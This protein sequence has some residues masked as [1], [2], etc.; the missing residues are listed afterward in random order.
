MDK[1]FA[2]KLF[3]LTLILAA[4]IY[5]LG[6]I[7]LFE[8]F[9]SFVWGSLIFLTTTTVVVY[10]IMQRAMAMKNHSNFVMAFGAGFGIK[11][12]ASLI[13]LCYFIVVAPIADHNFVL[14]FFA[15]YFAY[16]GLLV[17]DLW[18]YSKKK[19]LP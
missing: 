3:G 1:G 12:L 7:H 17:W 5:L 11:S 19:P 9:Q 6:L 16:T 10:F 18:Q 4:L 8:G 14:P 15:M 13:F 2:L